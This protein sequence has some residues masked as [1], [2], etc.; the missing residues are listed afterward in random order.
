MAN[1]NASSS[2]SYSD[3]DLS[4]VPSTDTDK[5]V[6]SINN[7]Y[8]Q[9]NSQKLTLAYHWE[10]NHL[11][12]DGNQW[13]RYYGSRESGGVW[14]RLDPT[15][16]NQYI[17]RPVTNYLFDVYQTLKSLLL[18]NKPRLSVRPNTQSHRDKAAAKLAEL[19]A[20]SNWEKLHENYNYEAAASCALVYGTVFKKDY[21]DSSSSTMVEIPLTEPKP[22][23]DEMTGMPT[24][25]IEDVPVI[26]PETGMPAVSR[27]PLGDIST[28][29]VEPYRIA[30]DPLAVNLHEARWIME[31]S[32][33]PLTW[34]KDNYSRNDNGYT[35]NADKVKEEKNVSSILQRF[36]NLRTSSGIRSSGTG[37]ID[38][39]SHSYAAYEMVE[40]SAV[41]KEYYERPS[42]TNPKGRLIVVANDQILYIGD[43]PYSGPEVGDWHPYSE[44]R[45][46]VVPGRFWGKSPFDDANEIQKIINS[47]DS[48]LILTRQTMAVPQKMIPLGSITPGQWTGQPGFEAYYKPGPNG[49]KPETIPPVGVDNQFFIERQFRVDELKQITGAIDILKGEKPSGVTAASALALLHEV[50]TGKLFPVTDRWKYFTESSQ[51]KQLRLVAAKYREPRKDYIRILLR[52]NSDL[53]EDMIHNFIGQDLYDNCNVIIEAASS[54]PKLKAAEHSLLIELATQGVLNLQDPKNRVEFLDKFGIQGFDAQESL[55]VKRA[56]WE[57]DL[58]D[59]ANSSD[60][61]KVIVLAIDNHAIHKEEHQNRMKHP[62]FLDLPLEV[63]QRY[64]EHI[65]QHDEME[66]QAQMMQDMQAMMGQQPA[67]PAPKENLRKGP[68][69]TDNLEEILASDIKGRTNDP[70]G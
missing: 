29:V 33:R 35:G 28:A 57:N 10:R 30:L 24:G 47:L 66:N 6:A 59:N 12:L 17:P 46:E 50:S 34:I 4:N 26:D 21:W 69:M 15:S 16:A 63:Q 19:V 49:E 39:L 70:Q 20:E 67:Q 53:T 51:K 7:Y 42:A 23:I 27:Q 54:V 68:G 38:F 45:W 25:E 5:L 56:Q 44:F 37:S 8:K 13:L 1:D 2:K 14:K 9:D 32:I 41:V 55:D 52:K 3:L 65:E 11:M 40:N 18:K 22:K 36:L 61:N 62:S 64:M 31:Y 58:M 48:T 60:D 43:S